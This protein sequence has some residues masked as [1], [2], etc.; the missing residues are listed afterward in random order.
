M[1]SEILWLAGSAIFVLLGSL[2]LI[3]L[4]LTTRLDPRNT[5][6]I[7]Q[8]KSTGLRLTNQT[9]VWKAWIGFNASHGLGLL[10]AGLINILLVTDDF[11]II[12]NSIPI[13]VVTIL[14]SGFYLWL[15]KKYW[16]SIPFIC[17]LIAVCCFIVSP[18]LS[19]IL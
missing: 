7:N 9:T 5:Q 12:E 4:F 6:L 17:I 15:A 18:V 11:S 10:F 2:H 13:S 3:Y 19:F 16:F 14:T 8:M 1:A